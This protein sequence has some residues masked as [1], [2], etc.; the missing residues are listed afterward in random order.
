MTESSHVRLNASD[1]SVL[2][3][4]VSIILNPASSRHTVYHLGPLQR[5]GFYHTNQWGSFSFQQVGLEKK[6]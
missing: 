4:N 1:N 2:Q 3:E 6:L 5:T